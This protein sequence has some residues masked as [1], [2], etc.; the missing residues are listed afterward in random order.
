MIQKT[1]EID[2][3]HLEKDPWGYESNSFDKKRKNILLAEIPELDYKNVL[4]IGC[5]QGFITQD[6]PGENVIGVDISEK[7]IKFAQEKNSEV[8]FKAGS[9][10]DLNTMFSSTKFDLIVITGVL[11]KQYIGQS[12]NL[13]YLIIDSLLNKNGVLL[14]VHID[15]WYNSSFPYLKSKELF[16]PYREFTHKLEVYIK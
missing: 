1:E 4:D 16:Y 5:G 3:W 14:C 11:Y 13:I 8:E 10:F 2:K 6:L 7:A 9:I 12:N 15:G